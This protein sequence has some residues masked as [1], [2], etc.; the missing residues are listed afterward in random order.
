M[1]AYQ[2]LVPDDIRD[3]Y[4]K[5]GLFLRALGQRQEDL[6]YKGKRYFLDNKGNN[7]W[8]LRSRSSHSRQGAKRRAQQRNA[9]IPKD[10]YV[11]ALGFEA[12]TVRYNEDQARLQ[13]IW[14]TRGQPG[15]DIDHINSLNDGGFEHPRNLRRQNSSRNRSDGARNLSMEARQALNL[16]A[17][18]PVDHVRLQGPNPSPRVRAQII[19]GSAHIRPV[20]DTGVSEAF[21]TDYRINE[22]DPLGGSTYVPEVEAP[23]FK[24]V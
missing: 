5:E 13:Q 21:N 12:G 23:L 15:F 19:N 3:A 16:H 4:I 10:V 20:I 6:V 8:R 22:A 11:Q 18:N 24:G 7:T 1:A 14:G 2:Q 17:D 9:T